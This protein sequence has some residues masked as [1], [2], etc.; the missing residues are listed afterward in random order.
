ML[1]NNNILN[2]DSMNLS[3]RSIDSIT[4]GTFLIGTLGS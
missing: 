4:D 2:A 1:N 3:I